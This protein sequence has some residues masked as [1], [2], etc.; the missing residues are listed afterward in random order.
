MLDIE[1]PR[2]SAINGPTLRHSEIPR[3]C[4]IVLAAEETTCQDSAHV[5]NGLVPGDGR[6]IVYPRLRG[7]NRGRYGRL[8][9]QTLTARPAQE[10]GLV[11]A[12]LPRAWALAEPLAQRPRLIRRDRRV[13][14]PPPLTR[15]RPD[16]WGDG[17]ALAGLGVAADASGT[18]GEAHGRDSAR[19]THRRRALGAYHRPG[20][21]HMDTVGCIGLGHRGAGMAGTI[22]QAGDPLVVDDTRPAAMR[23]FLDRDARP[24]RS[25]ASACVGAR[26]AA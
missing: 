6:P 15:Q 14:L 8:T 17:W 23:A 9:G 24:A 20:G 13:L 18:A 22:Q 25:P 16:L 1:V 26:W 10:M 7:L 4:D 2:I 21:R 12:V 3:L 19:R 11:H 5:A